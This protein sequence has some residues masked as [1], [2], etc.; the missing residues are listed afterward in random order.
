MS[1]H[2]ATLIAAATVGNLEAVTKYLGENVKDGLHNGHCT[3][4][5]NAAQNGHLAVVKEMVYYG[6]NINTKG[7]VSNITKLIK[8]VTVVESLQDMINAVTF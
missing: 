4:L 7:P 8:T 1:Q 5:I 6:A 3:A 2:W